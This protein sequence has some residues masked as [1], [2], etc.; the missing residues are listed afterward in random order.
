MT[1]DLFRFYDAIGHSAERVA[2]APLQIA[3]FV[4]VIAL[5]MLIL[6]MAY[7]RFVR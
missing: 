6:V 5:A 1:V 2:N 7:D 3:S 4:A